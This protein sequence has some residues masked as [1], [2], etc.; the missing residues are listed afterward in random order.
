MTVI[1]RF[2]HNH[3]VFTGELLDDKVHSL[4]GG[5]EYKIGGR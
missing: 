3:Q 2:R 5:R 4:I 1:G